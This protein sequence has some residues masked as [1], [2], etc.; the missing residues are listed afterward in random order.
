MIVLHAAPIKAGNIGGAEAAVPSLIAAQNRCNHVKAALTV[1][2][3]AM[4]D[5]PQTDFPVFECDPL[6][7]KSARLR[8]PAPFDRP[9]LVVFHGTYIPV[10]IA[11]AGKLRK[12]GIPYVICPHG[13]MTRF[14]Q[15]CKAWKKRIANALFFNSMV[16]GAA[17]LHCLTQGEAEASSGWKR[18]IFVVGNGVQLPPESKLASPGASPSLRL[19]FLGR[20]EVKIK[21]LDMLLDAC[22]LV[23]SALVEAGARVELCGPDWQGST[24]LLAARIAALGLENVVR[25][26]KPVTGEAK[27]ALFRGAD[28]FLHP[29]RS[30]GHPMAV[31]EALAH[32][33]PCLL[34]PNTNVASEVVSA[35]AGWQVEPSASGIAD[36]LSKLLSLDK[37]L[38]GEAGAKARRMAASQYDW[39]TVAGRTVNA[40]RRFAA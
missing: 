10:Q 1:T 2:I 11:I 40:Y 26:S 21:G 19:L 8:L 35:G 22:R 27:K 25:L 17:A 32:G 9:Q 12:A 31:L 20:M 39:Q 15:T 30:E 37:R 4:Q 5:L 14:A 18:P 29:S 13:G 23:R 38:L 36:G 6:L 28:V 3:P 34:T 33:V 16:A 7:D 24:R